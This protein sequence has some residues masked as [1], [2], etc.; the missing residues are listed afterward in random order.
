[1][2]NCKGAAA[3]SIPTSEE[4]YRIQVK[5]GRTNRR[6]RSEAGVALLIAIFV[7]LLIGV[8]AIALI[9]SSGTETALAGNY[10]S[11]TN[12]YYAA[13]AGLEE[14]RARLRSSDPNAFAKTAPA[15][16][17]PATGTAF[18]V[19]NPSYLINPLGSETVTPWVSGSTYQDTQFGQE[20]GTI[21]SNQ[22]PTSWHST[23][24]IWQGISLA[25]PGPR[26]KWVRIN[27]VSEQSLQLD[28]D[29][30]GNA[31]SSAPLYYN[32]AGFSNSSSAGQQ[33]LEVTA[34]AVLPNASQQPT[35]KLVQYLIVPVP[36]T[37]PPFLAALTISDSSV[38]GN[39]ATYLAPA[40]NS[41]FLVLGNDFGC[42]G[43]P[44]A[45][46]PVLAIGVFQSPDVA[47]VKGG[48]QSTPAS[49]AG[50]YTGSGSAPSVNTVSNTLTPSQLNAIVQTIQQNADAT[51]PSG[52][53]GAQKAFLNSLGMSP[54]NILTLVANGDLDLAGWGGTGYGLLLVTGTLYY[55]P[56]TSWNGIILVIGNGVLTNND[57]HL[58]G[59][60]SGAVYVANTQLPDPNLGGGVVSFSQDMDG[61]GVRYS[62]CWIQRAQPTSGYKVLSFHEIAQ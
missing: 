24:S 35:Q 13:V 44:T 20:L 62:S 17:L 61:N 43:N 32:G 31:D 2:Y 22:F 41:N 56:S 10:R 8:A 34:L 6:R 23:P 16:F 54:T 51:I 49:V 4:G 37:L 38:P 1:M 12:V 30:D 47:G 5:A 36:V 46:P 52:S 3:G 14:V 28:V 11:S 29:G 55:D 25:F 50:N 26:Y 21:C 33:V 27:G 19:C 40:N 42:N 58:N 48:I 60:I 45:L 59:L 57:K 53:P 18:S 7:L 15:G 39:S 9:V